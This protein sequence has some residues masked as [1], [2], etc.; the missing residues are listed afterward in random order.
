MTG[1]NWGRGIFKNAPSQIQNDLS[2]IDY[3]RSPT[4]CVFLILRDSRQEAPKAKSI[5]PRP[6]R[7]LKPAGTVK[8]HFTIPMPLINTAVSGLI[9]KLQILIPIIVEM[10]TAGIKDSAVWRISCLVVKPRAFRIP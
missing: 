6:A 3:I 7:I 2:P 9:I 8:V 1:F 5:I 10:T 4:G